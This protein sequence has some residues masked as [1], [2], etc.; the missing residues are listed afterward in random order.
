MNGT[1]DANAFEERRVEQRRRVLKGATLRF[2]GSFG[3]MEGVV[4]NESENGALLSFGDTTGV[5]P[6]FDLAVKGAENVR[7]ARLRWRLP[8]LAGIQFVD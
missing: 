7:A 2:N 6:G 8:T 3:A 4:R 5:P 1:A